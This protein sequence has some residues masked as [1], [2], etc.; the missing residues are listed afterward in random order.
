MHACH[1]LSRTALIVARF[2]AVFEAGSIG[3]AANTLRIPKQPASDVALI[4][5]QPQIH[6]GAKKDRRVV[7][8]SDG[9]LKLLSRRPQA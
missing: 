7:A 2:V 5:A 9:D 8:D 6:L 4:F 3:V 1:D